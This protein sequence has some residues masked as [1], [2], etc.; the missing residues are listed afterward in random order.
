MATSVKSVSE[1]FNSWCN[2]P[3]YSDTDFWGEII[4]TYGFTLRVV[5]SKDIPPRHSI[6]SWIRG[7]GVSKFDE[8]FDGSVRLPEDWLLAFP[9]RHCSITEI[10]G[11]IN[12]MVMLNK[13]QGGVMKHLDILTS[14]PYIISDSKSQIV[15]IIGFPKGIVTYDQD[16]MSF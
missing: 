9:E 5:V 4:D 1:I 12:Q 13:K 3:P 10:V 2:F 7:M 8:I 15:S 11:L 14:S 6:F 16:Y